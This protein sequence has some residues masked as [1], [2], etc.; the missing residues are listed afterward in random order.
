MPSTLIEEETAMPELIFTLILTEVKAAPVH[1]VPAYPAVPV[2]IAP[3]VAAAAVDSSEAAHVQPS[4][5]LFWFRYN[6]FTAGH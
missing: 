4:F 6:I 3:S 5:H 1:P 2:F